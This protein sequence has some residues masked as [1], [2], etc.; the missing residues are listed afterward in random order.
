MKHLV[1][2]CLLVSYPDLPR[3]SGWEC[4]FQVQLLTAGSQYEITRSPAPLPN[5]V[6]DSESFLTFGLNTSDLTDFI[7]SITKQEIYMSTYSSL[8]LG[9]SWF[10]S[11]HTLW[12]CLCLWKS[13]EKRKLTRALIFLSLFHKKWTP[14]FSAHAFINLIGKWF[15]RPNPRVK[16]HFSH[17]CP[18]GMGRN[19]S[20]HFR[21][22]TCKLWYDII[23]VQKCVK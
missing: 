15:P 8:S 14:M 11:I 2:P 13:R 3:P 6:E 4:S 17:G 22:C 23:Y 19:D 21:L 16:L 18:W 5:S 12:C 20:W 9:S 1:Y 7:I 10:H